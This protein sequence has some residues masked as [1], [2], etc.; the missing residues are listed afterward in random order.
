MYLTVTSHTA[1]RGKTIQNVH[2]CDAANISNR[3]KFIL[4]LFCLFVFF[5]WFDFLKTTFNWECLY[6]KKKEI[7]I[8]NSIYSHCN[9]KLIFKRNFKYCRNFVWA[10]FVDLGFFA[11]LLGFYFVDTSLFRFSKKNNSFLI[12]FRRGCK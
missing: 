9:C 4:P 11:Y 6:N 8:Y 1:T 12:C 5:I 3:F 7:W 10:N 2:K